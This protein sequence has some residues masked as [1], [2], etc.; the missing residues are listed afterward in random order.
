MQI[1]TAWPRSSP[2]DCSVRPAARS[3]TESMKVMDCRGRGARAGSD[4]GCIGR[5][6]NFSARTARGDSRSPDPHR[7]QAEDQSIELGGHCARLRSTLQAGGGATEL[8]RRCRGATLA[9]LVLGK[10][11]GSNSLCIAA[12]GSTT[13][14]Q[15]TSRGRIHS[16]NATASRAP[17]AARRRRDRSNRSTC[18]VQ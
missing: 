3:S 16:T 13:S 7:G 8:A 4:S 2:S 18:H 5:G 15:R 10:G 1:G 9:A 17:L 6:E 12:N 11:G 14:R